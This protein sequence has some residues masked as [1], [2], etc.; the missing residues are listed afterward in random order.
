MD[1][2]PEKIVWEPLQGGVRLRVWN[3]DRCWKAIQTQ[4][5]FCIVH[6]GV[7]EWQ[8]RGQSFNVAEGGIYPLEPGEVHT[9]RKVHRT[10][11]FSVFFLDTQWVSTLGG[12]LVGTE[13]PHFDARG[14]QLIESWRVAS[15]AA[16][17]NIELQSDSLAQELSRCIGGAVVHTAKR[18]VSMPSKVVAR[19][20]QMIRD[21]FYAKPG[22]TVNIGA[23]AK[24]VGAG[25]HTLVHEFS[26]HYGAPPYEYVNLLRA[27]Y[28]V[29]RLRS[30]PTS[31]VPSLGALSTAAGFSDPAHMSRNFRK[32]FYC[33]PSLAARQ[34]NDG[35]RRGGPF[36]V[37][38]S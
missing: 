22:Q 31:D 23:I 10:G 9:T 35:W 21:Q 30:G 3:S 27:Q 32:H 37:S 16:S 4:Y 18:R 19:A 6:R 2:C 12:E 1:T 15:R 24:D 5:A 11:D 25:Y 29:G 36:Q 33:S 28:V 20:R 8:Y 13:H 34:L 17:M 7:A 26:R 38:F 14:L